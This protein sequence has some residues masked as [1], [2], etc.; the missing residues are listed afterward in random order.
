MAPPHNT[1]LT[2]FWGDYCIIIGKGPIII[3]SFAKLVPVSVEP[4]PESESEPEPEKGRPISILLIN[5]LIKKLLG[6][7]LVR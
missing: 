7:G 4:E 2:A 6:F 1:L 5:K 3:P